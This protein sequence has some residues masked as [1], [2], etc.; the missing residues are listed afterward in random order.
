MPSDVVPLHPEAGKVEDEA[1][2]SDATE[3]SAE[4][5][6]E[7]ADVG[8]VAAA[9]ERAGKGESDDYLDE[10]EFLESLSLDDPDTFDAVSRMLDDEEDR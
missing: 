1:A 6:E 5:E 2:G 10:L 3:E 7:T 4:P 8:A 9:P